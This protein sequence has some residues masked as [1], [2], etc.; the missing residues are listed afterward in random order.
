MADDPL[1]TF[2]RFADQMQAV[3]RDREPRP[4]YCERCGCGGSI[5]VSAAVSAQ[6]L[7]RLH[8]NLPREES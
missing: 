4:A 5:E 2:I 8:A 3:Y 1:S 6:T 7:R